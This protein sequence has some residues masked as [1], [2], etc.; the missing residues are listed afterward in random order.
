[1][2]KTILSLMAIAFS[3]AMLTS[4]KGDE[5]SGDKKAGDDKNSE[6][7][8]SDIEKI[9]ARLIELSCEGGKIKASSVGEDSEK[10]KE[11]MK[12]VEKLGEK[13]DKYLM[14]LPESERSSF[15]K[16]FEDKLKKA[17]IDCGIEVAKDKLNNMDINDLS[18]P[19]APASGMDAPDMPASG[20]DAPAMPTPE[21]PE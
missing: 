6:K 18:A 19:E 17:A 8:S 20:M 16:K 12:E 4:C 9:Q 21:M 2:K 10:M 1:M 7:G 13:I 15:K 14:S 11:I 3:L 5:K